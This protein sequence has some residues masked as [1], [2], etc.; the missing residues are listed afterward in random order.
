VALTSGLAVRFLQ[1]RLARH[2]RWMLIYLLA[3]ALRQLALFPFSTTSAQYVYGWVTTEIVL[4][5]LRM[6]VA[7]ECFRLITSLFPRLGLLGI[8]TFYALAGIGVAITVAVSLGSG[9][10]VGWQSQAFRCVFLARQVLLVLASLFLMAT[11]VMTRT[12]GLPL[13][14]NI[15][16]HLNLS[17]AYF[18]SLSLMQMLGFRT[19]PAFVVPTSALNMSIP[20]A[21]FAWWM[22]ALRANGQIVEESIPNS[23]VLLK[24]GERFR[25]AR[26]AHPSHW[27]DG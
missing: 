14:P 9:S 23:E 20:A 17:L 19:A 24:P 6:L 12:L 15:R 4:T 3:S 2:Y 26:L 21:L 18:L 10:A 8:R 22:L 13:A 11:I 27:R 5:A 16:V 25:T 1:L 7:A